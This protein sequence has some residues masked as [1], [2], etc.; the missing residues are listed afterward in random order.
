LIKKLHAI[1]VYDYINLLCEEIGC[2]W[3]DEGKGL[4]N[5]QYNTNTINGK[6]KTKK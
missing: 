3:P 2:E 6:I 1:S 5:E 4:Y